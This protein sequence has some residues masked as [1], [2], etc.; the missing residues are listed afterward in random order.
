[1]GFDTLITKLEEFS[2]KY[3]FNKLLKGLIYFTG[4]GLVYFLLISGLEYFGRFNSSVRLFLLLLLLVGIG[5]ITFYY[6]I[7]PLL[8]LLRIRR[9]LDYTQAARLIGK[10]FPEVDDKILNTLQ[11]QQVSDSNST[12]LQA[13]IDQKIQKLS[14]VPFQK[15]IN[16]QENKKYWPVLLVPISIFLLLWLTGELSS[17]TES[18]RRIVQ[19]QQEF[20]PEAPFQFVADKEYTIERGDDL[21]L[22]LE[23]QGAKIPSSVLIAHPGGESRMVSVSAGKFSYVF[24]NV[25]E[26]FTFRYQASGFLSPFYSVKVIPVPK[27]ESMLIQVIPPAY[28]G[29]KSY[30]PETNNKFSVPEGSEVEWSLLAK[31]TD[32]AFFTTNDTSL[33]LVR[34]EKQFSLSQKLK[35]DLDYRIDLANDQYAKKGELANTVTILK[36]QYPNIRVEYFQDTLYEGVLFIKGSASDDYGFSRLQL[37]IEEQGNSK[38]KP[39]RINKGEPTLSFTEVLQM[40]SVLT[41]KS[42][43]L[44]IYLKLYDNDGINGPK[45]AQSNSFQLKLKGKEEIKK[46]IDEEYQ[47]V[48]NDRKELQELNDRIQKEI[49]ALQR[50]LLQS[51]K[52]DY[53]EQ[54]RLKELLQKEKDLIKRQRE[55]DDKIEKLQKK[56]DKVT[57][58]KEELKQKEEEMNEIRK[59]KKEEEL[60]RLME[61]IQ[62]LM[63]KLDTE[64]LQEKLEE[65]QQANEQN[66]RNSERDEK[67][68]EDL[69]FQKNILE[70]AEKLQDLAQQQKDLANK[71]ESSESETQKE[72]QKELEQVQKEIERLEKEN[73]NFKQENEEQ[74]LEKSFEETKE[75]MKQSQENMQ[76]RKPGKANQNQ[77]KAGDKMQEMSEQLQQSLMS[78]QSQSMQEDMVALRQILENLEILS[79]GVED[80]AYLSRTVNINDPQ[81]RAILIEQRK[82]KEG[83]KIIEDSLVALSERNSQIKEVVFKELS[84]VNSNLNKSIQELEERRTAQASANQQ[85]VMTAANN[86]ALMLDQSLQQMQQMMAM[87]KPG[88]QS[89]EKP[90]QGKP[91]LSNMRKLQQQLGEQMGQMKKGQKPGEQ[92]DG[93]GKKGSKG[94][95]EEL[96]RILSQQEQLRNQ[97]QEMSENMGQDGNR[98]NIQEA[99]KQM[100]ELEKELLNGEY[101][102]TFKDR[103]KNIETRLLE[104]ERAEMKQDEEEKRESTTSE[105]MKM[106]Q[107]AI[108]EYLKEKENQDEEILL[109]PLN[110]SNY[111]REKANQLLNTN[112]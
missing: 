67:L 8:G 32:R 12:L 72:F 99:I 83:A 79:H 82:L 45:A 108:E 97:L 91:S 17:I 15:A 51:K 107:M 39:L 103:L 55:L 61:E 4:T 95:S 28:T 84:D 63:E 102:Y 40:D 43:K 96:I 92:K 112:P 30:I 37:Y 53:R 57:E 18:G 110:L 11:L 104:S 86:L 54:E 64:K 101:E 85:H 66:Q 50:K 87:S 81:L 10:H 26:D 59:D 88:K 75:E 9:K 93:K 44:S 38:V 25:Q 65:L 71:E 6:V 69:K 80:L 111:Y 13:S 109:T 33:A 47:T 68:L 1:M 27:I 31:E 73:E 35:N 2:R 78:M 36:D 19:Y 24:E 23:L 74:E 106:K 90:G 16:L 42:R 60:E 70:Q 100:E 98:G 5:V 41:D 94:N 52:L 22:D 56:E 48:Q 20:L 58:K 3:Y 29:L 49:E 62:K 76:K 34:K 89:C 7:A 77:Q 105:E 46:D 21:E 14:L